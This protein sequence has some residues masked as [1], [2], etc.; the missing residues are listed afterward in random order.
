M[1]GDENSFITCAHCG[2]R[3]GV[4]EPLHMERPDGGVFRTSYLNLTSEELR[5]RPRLWHLWCLP[6]AQV[7]PGG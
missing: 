7:E 5:A 1:S 4:Y 3:I 6:E 2:E